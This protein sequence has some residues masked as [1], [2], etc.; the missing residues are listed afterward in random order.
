M[1]T[2]LTKIFFRIQNGRTLQN[3]HVCMQKKLHA[4]QY[5]LFP[6]IPW[7]NFS[8]THISPALGIPPYLQGKYIIHWTTTQHTQHMRY[9]DYNTA[10][11]VQG[12]ARNTTGIQPIQSFILVPTLQVS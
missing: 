8:V 1:S 7:G 4:E 11:L 9:I 10:A 3:K 12:M 6:P 5:S 2:I